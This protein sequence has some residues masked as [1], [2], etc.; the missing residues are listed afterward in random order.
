MKKILGLVLALGTALAFWA[1]DQTVS[2]SDDGGAS[3]DYIPGFN[4]TSSNSP[5]NS[6]NSNPAGNGGSSA[7]MGSSESNGGDI[8][9]DD[10]DWDDDSGNSSASSGLDVTQYLPD[11]KMD[12]KFSIDDDTWQFQQAA[13]DSSLD[14]TIKFKDNGDLWVDITG[15][16]RAE[17]EDA[18]EESAGL[19]T[20]I[21]MMAAASDE[22]DMVMTA[23]CDGDM[24]SMKMQG[25][26]D[27]KYTP[28]QKREMYA[29]M[30]N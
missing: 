7:S 9:A 6:S 20:F 14:M 21:G 15:E 22:T 4:P 2:G 19:I 18:C 28:E 13:A 11:Q 1:C 29:K 23:S 26:A 12:C 8:W 30:C 17:S 24:L 5:D 27:E 16:S 3:N 10:D 25:T